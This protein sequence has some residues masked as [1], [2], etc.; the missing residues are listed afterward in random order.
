MT[1]YSLTELMIA[2][3]A[4]EIREGELVFVGMRLPLIAFAVAKRTHA[5]N[6]LGLFEGGIL[7]D[8]VPGELLHTMGDPANIRGAAWCTTLANVMGLLA[9]GEVGIGLIGAAEIDRY[10]NVN[11][12][13]IG[14]HERPRV[15]LPGSGGGGDIACL[16]GRTVIILAQERHRFVERVSYVTS[17]GHGDG[18]CWRR[19]L[20]LPGGGPARVVTTM[21]AY[22]FES[23]EMVLE[24]VHPGVSPRDVREAVG[25]PL[26]TAETLGETPP[27]TAEELEAMR[28]YDPQGVWRS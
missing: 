14:P 8:D 24:S 21:A 9:R 26:R 23:G 5:P 12:T 2:A 4:R 16:A 11:T 1:G 10:G 3:T 7:R 25:W 20:G 18:G 6:A 27:P 22:G 19:D 28:A 13:V 17:P 15:R